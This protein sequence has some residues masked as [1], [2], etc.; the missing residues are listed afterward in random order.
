MKNAETA[1]QIRFVDLDQFGHVNNAIYLSYLEVSRLPYF[2]NII[3][4]ID[5]LN[6]GIILAKAE[7]DYKIPILLKD[8]IKIKTWCSRM[9]S[10]S[11]DLS[12]SILKTENNLDVEVATART[13][14]V[15]FN[16]VKQISIAVPDAWKGRML[17]T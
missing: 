11:F 12:Y 2:D 17:A 3:G 4:T 6:E 1:I 8:Q 16:Y 7:I 9:G 15:C 5:W 13:V 10:K 14:M